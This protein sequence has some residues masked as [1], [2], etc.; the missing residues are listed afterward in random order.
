VATPE[1]IPTARAI[2][3]RRSHGFLHVAALQHHQ[4]GQLIDHDQDEGQRFSGSSE[5]IS[6]SSN[7]L[8]GS[9]ASARNFFV[10]LI[11]VADALSSQQLQTPLH[12][13]HGIA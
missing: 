2:C 12:L 4:I 3:A 11:D 1:C 8:R 10:E 6:S 9:L 13:D 5:G 7:R